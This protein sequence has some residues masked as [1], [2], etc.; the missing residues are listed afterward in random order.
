MGRPERPLDASSGPIPAFA[1]DLRVLRHRAGNPSYRKL[2]RKALFSPSVLSSAAGGRRLPTLAVTLAFVSAC[3]GDLVA[4]ERRWREI[5]EQSRITT[6]IQ[7][8]QSCSADACGAGPII[9]RPAQLPMAPGTFMGRADVVADICGLISSPIHARRP[10]LI[11][12]LAGVGKSTTALRL[13]EKT[14]SQ[15]PDGQLYVDLAAHEP[16][17]TAVPAIVRD[18]LLALGVPAAHVTDNP[19]QRIGL[20]RSLLAQ[21]RLFALLDNVRHEAQ[22]RPLLAQSA[23]S[24]VVLTSRPRLLGLCD[25]HR[26]HL[27]VFSRAES[28]AL[29]CRLVGAA[30]VRAEYEAAD[31]IAELCGDLP[32][33]VNIAGRRIAARPGR[34]IAYT[35][36]QLTDRRRLLNILAVGDMTVRERF[37]SAYRSLS[38]PAR[39]VICRLGS[40]GTRSTTAVGVAT[41][42]G[43]SV[44]TADELLES[45]VDAGLVRHSAATGQYGIPALVGAFAEEIRQNVVIAPADLAAAGARRTTTGPWGAE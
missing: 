19:V 1:H 35:A 32:L 18:F 33:A 24:Q 11:S 38:P 13:A 5:A 15:F 14:A 3:G 27:D 23:H 41:A 44:D 21:R 31:A 37:A 28:L 45:L 20:Y 16:D 40:A 42:M 6:V 10:I 7:H 2:A 39:E 30:R 25:A 8:E 29:L 9:A 17:G 43:V 22:V 12:G 34:T 4:W 26:V 36:G